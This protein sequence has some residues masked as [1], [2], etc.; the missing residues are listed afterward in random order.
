MREDTHYTLSNDSK[1]AACF[2][3]KAKFVKSPYVGEVIGIIDD[4][5]K[6][7]HFL[8]AWSNMEIDIRTQWSINNGVMGVEL[9]L[10]KDGK[11]TVDY[12]VKLSLKMVENILKSKLNCMTICDE[13]KNILLH[14]KP[15]KVDQLFEFYTMKK[16]TDEYIKNNNLSPKGW[17]TD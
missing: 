1:D 5:K 17:V 12:M 2:T 9:Q 11:N 8:K 14:F 13:A 3:H 10:H 7:Y 4:D 16:E 15:L 6:H